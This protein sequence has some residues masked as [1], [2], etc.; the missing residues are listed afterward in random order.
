MIENLLRRSRTIRQHLIA[1]MADNLARTII[2]LNVTEETFDIGPQEWAREAYFKCET[3]E[4]YKY[5]LG[6]SAK[7]WKQLLTRVANIVRD[8]MYLTGHWKGE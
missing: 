7:S 5:Q 6:I 8:E 4:F 2:R 1:T 3:D